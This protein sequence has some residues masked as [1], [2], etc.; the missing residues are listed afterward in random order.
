MECGSFD[1]KSCKSFENVQLRGASKAHTH[2]PCTITITYIGTPKSADSGL[3]ALALA[4]KNSVFQKQKSRSADA[5][6]CKKYEKLLHRSRQNPY[7]CS[8]I[9]KM[10]TLFCPKWKSS[11][12]ASDS[13]MTSFSRICNGYHPFGIPLKSSTKQSCTDSSGMQAPRCSRSD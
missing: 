12:N 9:K 4:S 8:R 11:G 7:I 5:F 1:D 3:I 2:S 6:F 10:F 13:S